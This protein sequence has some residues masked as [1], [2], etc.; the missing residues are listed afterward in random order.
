M[1]DSTQG[2]QHSQAMSVLEPATVILMAVGLFGLANASG[3]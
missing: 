2:G 1:D 3:G